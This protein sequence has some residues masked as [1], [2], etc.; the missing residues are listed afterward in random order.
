MFIK[1]CPFLLIF[2]HSGKFTVSL[3]GATV[4]RRWLTF[5][6][7]KMGTVFFFLAREEVLGGGEFRGWFGGEGVSI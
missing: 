3:D 5:R 4:E 7:A 6:G 1:R 2:G